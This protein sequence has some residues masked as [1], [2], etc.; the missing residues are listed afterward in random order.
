MRPYRLGVLGE[1][2]FLA[3][4]A[5]GLLRRLEVGVVELGQVE[6]RQLDL[7]GGG[8]HEA[9]VDAAQRAAVDLERA[10]HQQQA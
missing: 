1:E 9:R 2:L 7:G 5:L 10:G 8:D 4:L 3:V 6:L